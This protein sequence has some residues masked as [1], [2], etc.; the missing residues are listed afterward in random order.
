MRRA[1][2]SAMHAV[3]FGLKRA[4]LS[5]V[6]VTRRLMRLVSPGMTAA[7]YDLM[8]VVAGEPERV[9]DFVKSKD[10]DGVR[11][12]EV[13]KKL[14]VASPVVSRMVRSLRELGWV[15]RRRCLEDERT[16]DLELTRKGFAMMRA[17]FWWVGRFVKRLVYQAL[18]EKDSLGR[19]EP[20]YLPVDKAEALL[21]RI[22]EP[23]H[24]TATLRYWWWSPDG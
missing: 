9:T 18:R 16:W 3:T 13:R 24:D 4:F 10:Y 20:A 1:E 11:Q 5:S 6:A 15:R 17:A 8:Y 2:P 23:C 21:Q 12:S 7:R 22:R 19:W 14:G